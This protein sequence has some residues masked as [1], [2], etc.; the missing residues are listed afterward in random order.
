[1][2]GPNGACCRTLA[3][4]MPQGRHSCSRPQPSDPNSKGGSPLAM[5]VDSPVSFLA[6][7]EQGPQVETDQSTNDYPFSWQRS[8]WATPG[9]NRSLALPTAAQVSHQFRFGQQKI[10]IWRVLKTQLC[11]QSGDLDFAN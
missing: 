1:M 7:D 11:R 2:P 5:V 9:R 8:R 4:S 3:Q 6:R 10:A